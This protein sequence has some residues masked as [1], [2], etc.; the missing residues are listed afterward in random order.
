[1]STSA[2]SSRSSSGERRYIA[3]QMATR[4]SRERRYFRH[5]LKVAFIGILIGVIVGL[6]VSAWQFPTLS[7]KDASVGTVIE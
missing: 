5:G 6:I 3:Y 2:I 7:Q 1:M 4:R